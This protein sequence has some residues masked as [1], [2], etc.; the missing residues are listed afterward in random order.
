MKIDCLGDSLTAGY[1]VS[2][3]NRW[4]SLLNSRTSHTWVN[5]GISGDTS[6]GMLTRLRTDV[7]P[8]KPDYVIW[9]GGF[10]DILLTGS[11]HQAKSCVMAFVN[12]CAAAGV[13]PVIG[14]P[15]MIRS[16]ALPWN[17]LCDWEACRPVLEGYISWLHRLS[18][19]AMLRRIDFREAG[20]WLQPDGMHPSPE[21]HRRMA[22]A[23]LACGCFQ[24]GGR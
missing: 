8:E 6:P 20:A 1:G 9:L 3:E 15:Y 17:R 2:P 7:L 5:R 10:N 14:I 18:D 13:R 22:E 23:V 21:G 24:E 19:A 4:V 11:D 16:V 12:H